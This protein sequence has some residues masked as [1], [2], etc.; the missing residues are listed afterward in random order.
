LRRGERYSGSQYRLADLGRE[1][2]EQQS[3]QS[4]IVAGAESELNE[5]RRRRTYA[6]ERVGGSE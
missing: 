5:T 6:R 1:R 2:E 3:R 4:I